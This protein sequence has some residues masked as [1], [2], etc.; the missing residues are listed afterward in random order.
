MRLLLGTRGSELAMAQARMVQAALALRGIESDLVSIQTV[1]DVKRDAPIRD[2]GLLGAFVKELDA[3][4]RDGRVHAAVH[5]LKDVPT[6]GREGLPIAA[7]LPRDAPGDSLVGASDL[8]RLPQ[9]ARLGTSSLRRRAQLLRARPDLDVRPLRGNV[10]TR[11]AKVEA[12]DLDGVLL[13][14]AGLAR[15]GLAARGARL[16]PLAFPHAPGQGVVA[17]VAGEGSVARV[18]LAAIDDA[19][20]R[21][22]AEVERAVMARLGGGCLAA[23]GVYARTA[24][25]RVRVVAQ[26]LH[27]DGREV[28]DA[29][30]TLDRSQA[31]AGAEQLASGMLARGAAR[32]LALAR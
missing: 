22:A 12:G 2:L 8:S 25:D 13:A 1:G 30:A 6:I 23:L 17:V 10:A 26:V 7:V 15:L 31:M 29:S 16:D 4:V 32:L 21:L 27:P 24:G 19:D 28:V 9:G 20:T 18:A 3:A 11:L 14:T 5:S